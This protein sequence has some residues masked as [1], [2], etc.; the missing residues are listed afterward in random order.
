MHTRTIGA[1]TTGNPNE[2]VEKTSEE[3]GTIV[4]GAPPVKIAFEPAPP[5]KRP[6]R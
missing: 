6:E 3:G 1:K 2:F 4:C 5:V